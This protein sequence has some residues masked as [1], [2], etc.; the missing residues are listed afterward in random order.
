VTIELVTGTPGAGKTCYVVAKRLIAE[1]T[2]EVEVEDEAGIKSK[3]TRRI[4]VAGI[5]GLSVPHER[6]PHTLT[7]ER[8]T[9]GDIS[10][11]N[12]LDTDGE[13]IHKRLPGDPPREVVSVG[14]MVAGAWCPDPVKT[15]PVEASLF[16]WWLWCK[17]GDLIVCDEVQYIVPRGTLGKDPPHYIKSLE[18]HRH[19]GVDFIFITQDVTLL[20]TTMRR[21][22]GLHRHVRAV[23]GGLA[24]LCMVYEWDHASNPE[25][26][27]HAVKAFYKR[28]PAYFK[29]YKS[30]QAVI[31]PPKSGRAFMWM[32]P[33][34]FVSA[35]AFAWSGSARWRGESPPAGKTVASV[36]AATALAAASAASAGT[37]SAAARGAPPG[38]R[39]D[40]TLGVVP[41]SVSGCYTVGPVCKCFDGAFMP[42]LVTPELCRT[43]AASYAGIV[44]WKKRDP[45]PEGTPAYGA[46]TGGA[47]AAKD[48][49]VAK[50]VF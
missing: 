28:K 40:A 21:L 6:L 18:I 2:R 32:L 4:V 24:G 20:D 31:A 13:P 12:A 10:K 26:I 47:I 1:G 5:R 37:T 35:G 49:A 8:V 7:G 33:L 42:I 34:L 41:E 9:V 48:V 44:K 43:S 29:L 17:P 23:M 11:W 25:R 30:T 16:N 39:V 45:L 15:E 38:W 36:S 50:K 3:V 27:S 14:R 22:V 46:N 19:Y